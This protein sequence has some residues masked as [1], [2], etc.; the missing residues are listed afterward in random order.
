MAWLTCPSPGAQQLVEH[1]SASDFS[2]NIC[3]LET[4]HSIFS[5]WRSQVRS[6]EL[7]ETILFAVGQFQDAFFSL[8]SVCDAMP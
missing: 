8:F 4:A 5:P 6:N 7:F 3:V 2:V 1:L